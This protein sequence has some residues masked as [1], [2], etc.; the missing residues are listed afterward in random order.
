MKIPSAPRLVRFYRFVRRWGVPHEETVVYPAVVM[1]LCITQ[2]ERGNFPIWLTACFSGIFMLLC[3]AW[4]GFVWSKPR[5][6]SLVIRA[7]LISLLVVGGVALHPNAP[8]TKAEYV[9]LS[10]DMVRGFGLIWYTGWMVGSTLREMTITLFISEA[11]RAAFEQGWAYRFWTEFLRH[12]W[13]KI[14]FWLRLGVDREDRQKAT[15]FDLYMADFIKSLLTVNGIRWL[16][17]IVV[18]A[19]LILFFGTQFSAYVNRTLP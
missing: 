10:A 9:Q 6:G 7:F 17:A 19:I 8:G 5:V 2:S 15:V 13:K 18:G 11:R 14:S 4:L 12:P 3:G 16:I 1:L